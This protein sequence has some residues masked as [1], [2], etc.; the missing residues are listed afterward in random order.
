MES[1]VFRTAGA[2]AIPPLLEN[3]VDFTTFEDGAK[4]GAKDD[5]DATRRAAS[6]SFI[7]D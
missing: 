2:K 4:R 5:A 7:L 3:D 1:S 6:A